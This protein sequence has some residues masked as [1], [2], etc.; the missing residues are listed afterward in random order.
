MTLRQRANTLHAQKRF[1]DDTKHE[2][3]IEVDAII[4][5]RQQQVPEVRRSWVGKLAR[6]REGN[7][8]R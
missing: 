3:I 8:E 1:D 4:G 6:G 7:R 2:V 5:K